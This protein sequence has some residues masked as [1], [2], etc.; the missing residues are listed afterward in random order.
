MDTSLR[1]HTFKENAKVFSKLVTKIIL[2]PQIV[3]CGLDSINQPNN[4][5]LPGTKPPAK[6][7]RWSNP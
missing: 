2:L 5:E 7:Y 4:P 6:E 3:S 1:R